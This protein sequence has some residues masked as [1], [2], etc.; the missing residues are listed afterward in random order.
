MTEQEKNKRII[1]ILKEEARK[2]LEGLIPA[3]ELLNKVVD[4]LLTESTE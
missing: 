3:T 2:Y 4:L 1:E